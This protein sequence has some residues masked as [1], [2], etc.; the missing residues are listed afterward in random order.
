MP[1]PILQYWKKLRQRARILLVSEAGIQFLTLFGVLVLCAAV[2]FSA[3]LSYEIVLYS[4]LAI[5][6]AWLGWHIWTFAQRWKIWSDMRRIAERVESLIP[7]LAGRTLLVLDSNPTD[8]FLRE[9]AL[10]KSAAILHQVPRYQLI[11]SS[12]LKH[13]VKRLA[14]TVLLLVVGEWGLPVSPSQALRSLTSKTQY[15]L[16]Q[17]EEAL[18][19][20]AEEVTIGD[21]VIEYTFPDYTGMTPVRIPNSNG[22]IHA[23]QGTSV[24]LSAKTLERF[25]AVQLSINDEVRPATLNFGREIEVEFDLLEEGSYRLLFFDGQQ[26]IPSQTFPLVFDDDDPPVASLEIKRTQIPSNRSISM[27]WNASDDFG[28]ERVVLEVKKGGQIKS[29]VLRK[30]NENRLKLGAKIRRSIEELGLQGGDT[31]VLQL[32]AYDNQAPIGQDVSPAEGEPFGK[33]GV[34]SPI[35]VQI[36]TPQMS[37][38]QMKQLNKRLRD[39]LVLIL[40]DYLVEDIPTEYT[41][42]AWSKRAMKRYDAI[43]QITDEAWAEGWPTY[44]SAELVANIYADSASLFRF[45]R[46]T[47]STESLGEPT[48]KD[49]AFFSESYSAHIEQLEQAIYI[50]DRMLRQVAFK[51]VEQ[52]SKKLTRSSDKLANMDMSQ[53]STQELMNALSRINRD[54]EQIDASVEELGGYS[55]KDFVEERHGE[56]T[57]MEKKI[58]SHLATEQ[59]QEARVSTEQFSEAVRQFAEGVSEMLERMRAQEDELEQEMESLIEKLEEL[60]EKQQTKMKELQ[61]ARQD[62]PF[63]EALSSLWAELEAQAIVA[64]TASGRLLEGIGDGRGFR[65]GTI[66]SIERLDSEMTALKGA[67]VTRNIDTLLNIVM[68]SGIRLRRVENVLENEMFRGRPSSDPLPNTLMNMKQENQKVVGALIEIQ[69]L[70]ES[71]ALNNAE[72]NPYLMEVAQAMETEQRGLHQEMVGLIPK[73]EEVEQQMPTSTGEATEFAMEASKNMEQSAQFLSEGESLAGESLQFQSSARIQDT[74]EALKQAAAQMQQM[75]Q[76]TDQMA[77]GGEGDS[78]NM[79]DEVELPPI[80]PRVSPEEYRKMLLQGMQAGVPE[81]YETLKKKYYEELVA[82]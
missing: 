24:R 79:S 23:P 68:S 58:R 26:K 39:A 22:E 32:V 3:K 15:V 77:G 75:Q 57:R 64:D 62:D 66:R 65:Y 44:L 38:D 56:L 29:V 69:R 1:K 41:V 48:S 40:A 51:E 36:L 10:E 13:F 61:M 78:E 5:S 28:L 20:E 34:S 21:I 7:S 71:D 31:A 80:E 9:R 25:E 60:D 2:G 53:K 54:L 37:A 55:I 16:A 73:V 27:T 33:R 19:D 76:Q 14:F 52:A 49:I 70:L 45:V 67:A 35:E 8:S 30:P 42:F 50:I 18:V 6:I 74:I 47:Y 17:A 11:P 12:R 59:T 82:Q 72:S 43:R 46:T 81:E 4:A 63:A